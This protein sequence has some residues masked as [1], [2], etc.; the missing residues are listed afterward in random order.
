MVVLDPQELEAVVVDAQYTVKNAVCITH[1]F[2]YTPMVCNHSQY[3]SVSST[4]Y[5]GVVI[6]GYYKTSKM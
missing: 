1:L 2:G 4:L 3:S 6:N 5:T